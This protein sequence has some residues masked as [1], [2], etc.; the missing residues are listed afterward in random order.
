MP[1]TPDAVERISTGKAA[2]ICGI[3]RKTLLRLARSGKVP[4]AVELDKGLWRYDEIRLRDWIRRREA[5]CQWE[6][7]TSIS[8]TAPGTLACKSVGATYDA[9]YEQLL[10]QR[11]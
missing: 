3:S 8:G 1:R 6:A 2:R 10:G 5:E 9:A 4:G 11:R 7:T